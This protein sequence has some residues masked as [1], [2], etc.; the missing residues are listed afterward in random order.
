M[1]FQANYFKDKSKYTLQLLKVAEFFYHRKPEME[2]CC[3]YDGEPCKWLY[4]LSLSG[5]RL[6][7]ELFEWQIL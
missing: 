3:D 1:Q 7:S 4:S 2:L 6:G 5:S